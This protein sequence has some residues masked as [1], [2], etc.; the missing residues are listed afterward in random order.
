MSIIQKVKSFFTKK[1]PVMGPGKID[2]KVSPPAFPY[3]DT[4]PSV[5]SPYRGPSTVAQSPYRAT[6]SSSPAND[7]LT[8]SIISNQFESG[9]VMHSYNPD[10]Y[11]DHYKAP[12]AEPEPVRVSTYTA[13]EPSYSK[14][15]YSSG[16]SSYSSSSSYDSGS[17]SSYDS[18]SSS[19]SWD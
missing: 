6:D 4:K 5:A 14:P 2:P 1:K 13:P 15:S 19:S 10:S 18:G 16:E 8:Y 3:R 17:S 7:M 12:V 9:G 11:A